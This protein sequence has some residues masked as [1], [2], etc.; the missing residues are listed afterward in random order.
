MSVT[1]PTTPE[2]YGLGKSPYAVQGMEYNGNQ[3][4]FVHQYGGFGAVGDNAIHILKSTNNGLFWSEVASISPSMPVL[5]YT[6]CQDGATAYI[7]YCNGQASNPLINQA[8]PLSFSSFDMGTDSLSGPTGSALVIYKYSGG[9]DCSLS[10]NRLSSGSM[11]LVYS[12]QPN[13]VAATDYWRVSVASFNGTIFGSPTQLPSQASTNNYVLTSANVDDSSI[14]HITYAQDGTFLKYVG[15]NGASFGTPVTLSSDWGFISNVL[16][17]SGSVAVGTANFTTTRTVYHASSGSVDP[18]W[19]THATTVSTPVSNNSVVEKENPLSLGYLDGSVYF[20]WTRSGTTPDWDGR[21]GSGVIRY[22][23]SS[24][25][26]TW[27]SEATIISTPGGADWNACQVSTFTGAAL[28]LGI[29]AGF[30]LGDGSQNGQFVAIPHAGGGG[31][32]TPIT[33]SVGDS[34]AL[35]DPFAGVYCTIVLPGPADTTPD[36]GYADAVAHQLFGLDNGGGGG[37]SGG[38]GPIEPLPP[39]SGP[40]Q[41]LSTCVFEFYE[42]Q[43]PVDVEVLPIPRKYDQLGPMRF[44]KIGKIFGFRVRLIPNDSIT[45]MPYKIYGDDSESSPALNTPLFSSSFAVAAGFDKVYE[46]QLPKSINTDIFRLTLGPTADSFHRYDV[47]VKVHLSGMKGQ[48]R[49]LP[50]R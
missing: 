14:L 19:T 32:G 45:D 22:I 44:D 33:V 46:I 27:T 17:Y 11:V 1:L 9:P 35:T 10:L 15:Y 18:T 48:A 41:N 25:L 7:A 34:N 26:S 3:Y 42:M 5:C 24:D 40:V 6:V 30:A 13:N 23:I 39:P 49:W 50:I 12:S 43:T 37:N 31:G 36:I 2:G 38:S 29:F 8:G 21:D 47:Q 20:F 16:C 4:L 28:G